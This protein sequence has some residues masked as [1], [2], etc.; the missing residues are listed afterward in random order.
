MFPGWEVR[1]PQLAAVTTR[2]AL[3]SVGAGQSVECGADRPKSPVS[4][5]QST[6]ETLMAAEPTASFESNADSA[7]DLEPD[8]E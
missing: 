7:T 6:L 3:D 4:P 5:T 2:T 1:M 8:S